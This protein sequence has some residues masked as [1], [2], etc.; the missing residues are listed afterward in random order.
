MIR[1]I[2]DICRVKMNRNAPHRAATPRDATPRD[3]TLR[4]IPRRY[5]TQRA[6]ERSPYRRPLL[7]TTLR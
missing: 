2:V 7:Q 1:L 3:A 4:D 6:T 5:A